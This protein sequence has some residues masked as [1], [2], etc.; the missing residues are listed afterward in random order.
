MPILVY[1]HVLWLCALSS[2][3]IF[4]WEI[5]FCVHHFSRRLLWLLEGVCQDAE[6]A[7]KIF[8]GSKSSGTSGG[9]TSE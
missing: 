9:I 3:S 2:T 8:S 6:E 7:C 4:L 5:F 1:S